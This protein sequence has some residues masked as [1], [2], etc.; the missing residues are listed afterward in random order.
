MQ[1]FV[2]TPTLLLNNYP[3][4]VVIYLGDAQKYTVVLIAKMNLSAPEHF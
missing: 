1:N 4:P 3:Q 2:L